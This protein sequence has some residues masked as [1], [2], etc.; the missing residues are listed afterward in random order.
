M[1]ELFCNREGDDVPVQLGVSFCERSEEGRDGLVKLLHCALR[2][3]W[4]VA[5][6]SRVT[7]TN[8][9]TA[10]IPEGPKTQHALLTAGAVSFSRA[11]LAEL[12]NEAFAHITG[13][14]C[15]V[16]TQWHRDPCQEHQNGESKHNNREWLHDSSKTIS[17]SQEACAASSPGP[18]FP[19][20]RPSGR[21]A[22]VEGGRPR[23]HAVLRAAPANLRTE[24]GRD[25]PW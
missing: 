20:G 18:K 22:A 5:I 9:V 3:W 12:L 10:L 15:F 8:T 21:A 16:T 7:H 14:E 23:L 2:S 6:V 13:T 19:T 4:R 25:R 11:A 1:W 24:R 17:N